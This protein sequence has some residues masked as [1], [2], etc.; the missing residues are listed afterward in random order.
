M[1][2]RT[3]DELATLLGHLRLVDTDDLLRSMS[4]LPPAASADSLL[5]LLERQHLLTN[6]QTERI[7]KD[8]TDGLVLG[9]YKL[10]YR[11]ASGSFARV[12]RAGSLTDGTMIGLKVLRERWANDADMVRLFHREGDLGQKLKHPNIVP[13]YG[14][15]VQGPHHYI[16]MEFVEG[17]NLRDF[18]KIR[19][20]LSPAEA[21]RYT[22]DMSRGLEHALKLG[23]THRDLK[24]TNVLMS[25]QGVAK[26][27]DFGLAADEKL[28][29]R[30]GSS[31]LQQAVEYSTLEQG[32]GAPANDPRSDLFFLGVIL[33]ELLTG[34]PPYPRTRD[35]EERKRF[36]RYRDVRPVT[37]LE[38][39]LPRRIAATVDRLLRINP[40]ERFQSPGEVAAEMRLAL[41][42]LGEAPADAGENG[43]SVPTVLCV[44]DRPQQ[45]EML[46][47]Y[48]SK[49]GY[50]VL[51]LNDVERAL[52]R[53]RQQA[54]D[55]VLLMGDS[56]GDRVA[57][58][59]A[60]ILSLGRSNFTSAILVLG[61]DQTS[62]KETIASDNPLGRVLVQPVKLRDLRTAIDGGLSVRARYRAAP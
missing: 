34:V 31:D 59:Y 23:I 54:P 38:P 37:T 51:L 11:N 18:V 3:A 53:I 46:R 33:Y 44:E 55:C 52:S 48:L 30:I 27:I 5:A 2:P 50:R 39:A 45:Q 41:N 4:E 32:S 9:G 7:R 24:M 1:P 62:L 17:G 60:R 15:G 56:I 35:K 16:A 21:A 12:Y 14:T 22:I 43:Q 19:G 40:A 29:S 36:S 57:E 42:E 25:S 58:D 61:E 6:L 47:Q 49:H 26:L 20:S 28:L 13:V 10:L 8:E